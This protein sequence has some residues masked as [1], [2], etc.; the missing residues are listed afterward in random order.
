MATGNVLDGCSPCDGEGVSMTGK[1][2]L[3]LFLELTSSDQSEC[4]GPAFHC[5]A[6]RE[7][8]FPLISEF[9]SKE[10]EEIECVHLSGGEPAL[11]SHLFELLSLLGELDVP[12]SIYSSGCWPE[13]LPLIDTLVD[14]SS[15]LGFTFY[16]HDAD[17]HTP[18]SFHSPRSAEAGHG[19][20]RTAAE[21]A[22]P[23]QIMTEIRAHNKK[24]IR[25]LIAFSLQAGA[26]H[27]LFSRYVGPMRE[28][29]SI[30]RRDL[31]EILNYIK[32]LEKTGLPVH[33]M[34]C[35]PGCFYAESSGC[36][37]GEDFIVIT[38]R[39]AVKPCRFTCYQFGFLFST[40]LEKIMQSDS[41]N[42]WKMI[43]SSQCRSCSTAEQCGGGCPVFM[44]DYK[45]H[46][47]PLLYSDD[48]SLL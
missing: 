26:S 13:P 37:A 25:E 24:G 15:F 40:P 7:L 17:P 19:A 31:R 39:G 42:E 23:F 41:A 11:Y 3:H 38:H 2:S 35:F 36:R 18:M 22:L 48:Y 29:F 34:P 44:H 47:D 9:L 5:D 30:N 32:A 12:Y 27:H 14:S 45:M 10:R 21:N 46:C 20:L 8:P 28:G 33:S 16:L 4:S 43:H 1:K 6:K